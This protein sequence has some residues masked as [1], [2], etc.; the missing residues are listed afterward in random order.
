[1]QLHVIALLK[2]V[3]FAS[4]TDARITDHLP[5]IGMRRL[6]ALRLLQYRNQKWTRGAE[7]G[8]VE[9]VVLILLASFHNRLFRLPSRGFEELRVG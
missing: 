2:R 5:N 8:H 1:M 3:I 7:D 4:R 6:Q 9:G